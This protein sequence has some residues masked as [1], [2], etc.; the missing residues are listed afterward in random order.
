MYTALVDA[1]DAARND[2]QVRAVILTGAGTCFTAG[3]DLQDF[4]KNPPLGADSPVM[5]FLHVISRFSKPLLAAV[6]GVAV[7]IGTTMLLHCDLAWAAPQ[8]RFELPFARL[9]LVPEGAASYLLPLAIGAKQA[10]AML[11]SGEPLDAPT[12]AQSGLINGVVETEA[13]R[14]YVQAQAERLASLPPQA[15]RQ[16][17]ALL[18]APHR[19]AID[20][21]LNQ[22]VQAFARQLQSA[23]ARAAMQAFFARQQ[24]A[25][26]ARGEA[27]PPARS[28]QENDRS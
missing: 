21:A 1:L 25:A 7:G 8:A 19:A 18:R 20:A 24:P 26:P 5:R 14:A 3:K 13:L 4:L 23:E 28:H 6:P 2:P 15:L 17:K 16:T 12:A 9:A 22:E 10:S 27:P 11:L